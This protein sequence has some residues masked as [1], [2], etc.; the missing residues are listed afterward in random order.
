MTLVPSSLEFRIS[1]SKGTFGESSPHI[2]KAVSPQS[3]GEEKHLTLNSL[4]R[5]KG[6][7]E[8]FPCLLSC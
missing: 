4:E 2:I 8:Y 7:S 3:N 6:M 5:M 1:D